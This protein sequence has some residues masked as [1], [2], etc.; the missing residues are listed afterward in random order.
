MERR[1]DFFQ[2]PRWASRSAA[3]PPTRA[4]AGAGWR[5]PGAAPSARPAGS[6]VTGNR[7][8]CPQSLGLGACPPGRIHRENPPG[9]VRGRAAPAPALRRAPPIVSRSRRSAAGPRAPSAAGGEPKNCR[10]GGGEAPE[11]VGESTRD[12]PQHGDAQQPGGPVGAGAEEALGGGGRV[13]EA[14]TL[15]PPEPDS[16]GSPAPTEAQLCSGLASSTLPPHTH[17][18]LS[19][20]VPAPAESLGEGPDLPVL[21]ERTWPSR[22]S[23]PRAPRAVTWPNFS[24][25]SCHC[26][27]TGVSRRPTPRRCES[28]D[29]DVRS[30][31]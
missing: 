8:R 30:T 12:T 23:R 22:G 25:P 2:R 5:G 29:W 6:R 24:A 28:P 3:P 19:R 11:S 13:G 9:R 1:A 14:T 27:R 17:P 18:N 20:G 31:R 21:P 15:P 16:A 7:R 26:P 4:I 10:G